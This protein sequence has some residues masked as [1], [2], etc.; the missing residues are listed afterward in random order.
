M[1]LTSPVTGS[2]QTGFTAPTYPL[3]ADKFSGNNGVQYAV[4]GTLGGTQTGATSQTAN[5]PFVVSIARPVVVKTQVVNANGITVSQG[6]NRHEIRVR[7]GMPAVAGQ[8]P[9]V[10]IAE[11][12]ISVPVGAESVSPAEIRA[13]LSCFIGVLTQY[14]AALGDQVITSTVTA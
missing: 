1:A 7:K 2:A 11:A 12:I 10:A 13:M 8:P 14:S 3:V 9:L 4:N 6:R 5:S